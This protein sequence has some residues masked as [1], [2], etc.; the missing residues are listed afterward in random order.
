MSLREVL[1]RE[2]ITMKKFMMMASDYELKRIIHPKSA[3]WRHNGR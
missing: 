2:G 3:F 1:R